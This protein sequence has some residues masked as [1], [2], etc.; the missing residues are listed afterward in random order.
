MRG[1]AWKW[2]PTNRRGIQSGTGFKPK[3]THCDLYR[4]HQ[5]AAGGFP[6]MG[7]WIPIDSFISGEPPKHPGHDGTAQMGRCGYITG[8]YML[9]PSS[10]ELQSDP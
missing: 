5:G 4:F 8:S 3:V 7:I 2:F 6:I 10:E 9:L 1:I